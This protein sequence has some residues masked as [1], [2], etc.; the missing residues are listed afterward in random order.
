MTGKSSQKVHTAEERHR[1]GFNCAQAVLSTLAEAQG[2]DRA[3]ALKI[4]S[5]FGGGIGRSGETCGAVTGALMA[6]GVQ[7][8]FSEPDPQAKDRIYARTREFLSR[9]RERYGALACKALIGVDLSTPEGLSQARQ[10]D[11][12]ATQC[13]HY[14]TGAIEIAEEMFNE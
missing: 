11:V 14:I 3:T 7:E 13:N 8:G 9:F 6:L 4:A 1:Q 10:Q 2:L 5:P 12:F